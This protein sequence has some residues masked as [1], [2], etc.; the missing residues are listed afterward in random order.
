MGGEKAEGPKSLMSHFQIRAFRW[1][2]LPAVVD[3]INHAAGAD[4]EDRRTS[5]DAL[6][7][8]FD[9]PQTDPE[10]DGFVAVNHA[11][12]IVGFCGAMLIDDAGHGRGMGAVHPGFRR[13]GIGTH[14]LRHS[15]ARLMARGQAEVHAEK[16]VYIYRECAD[17]A[18]GTSALLTTEGYKVVRHFITMY[19]DLNTPLIPPS[20]PAGLTLRHFVQQ[21]D[22]RAVYEAQ[23]EA[24]RDHWGYTGDIPYRRWSHR[25][26]GAPAFDPSLWLI[27]CDG[28]EIAGVC[29]S[30]R[31]GADQPDLAWVRALGVRQP[32]RRR[33][34][35]AVL[36]RH[37]FQRF[38]ERGF[39]RAGL[40][41]DA[42][43]TTNAVALY[44]RVGMRAHKRTI[45]YRR[46]LRGRET[47]KE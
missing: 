11:G 21:R 1:D 17:T 27:A 15:D 37:S 5:L 46:V 19:I 42:D 3:V 24:F 30:R 22:A 25:M 8:E 39:A 32:W 41:V 7:L 10:T 12:Q 28:D 43:S 16:P 47:D 40:S 44:E 45:L 9:A 38:Q 26:L 35:G 18:T 2:D 20:L 33:G 34:L 23:Q 13:R 4:Q 36:L 6:R 31:L 14:L 29:L